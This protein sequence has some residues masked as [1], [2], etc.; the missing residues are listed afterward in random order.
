M[1]P[2][3]RDDHPLDGRAAGAARFSRSM[4]HPRYAEVIA[5]A[6][7]DGDVRTVGRAAHFDCLPEDGFDRREQ[8]LPLGRGQRARPPQRMQ[9]GQIQRF[10]HVDIA[11]SGD[12]RLVQ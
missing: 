1:C 11:E 9:L 12:E 4:I 8:R 6:A 7:A 5:T 3:S 2:P 10:I